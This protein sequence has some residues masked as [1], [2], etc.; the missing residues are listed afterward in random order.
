MTVSIE[1]AEREVVLVEDAR[2]AGKPY[3]EMPIYNGP[4]VD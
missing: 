1:T 2:M 4:Y 3:G